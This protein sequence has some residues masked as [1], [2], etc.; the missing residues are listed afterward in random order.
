MEVQKVSNFDRPNLYHPFFLNCCTLSTVFLNSFLKRILHLCDFSLFLFIP[1]LSW[2]RCFAKSC[3]I[4]FLAQSI[5]NCFILVPKSLCLPGST[6]IDLP[7][8]ALRLIGSSVRIRCL[9][10]VTSISVEP[11]PLSGNS[12]LSLL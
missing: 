9:G 5:S 1:P 10:R 4:R 12:N 11:S 3:L 6:S 7:V 8:L 2:N